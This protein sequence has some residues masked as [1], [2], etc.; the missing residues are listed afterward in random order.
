MAVDRREQTGERCRSKATLAPCGPVPVAGRLG[1][2][3]PGCGL[4]L[5]GAWTERGLYVSSR[6]AVAERSLTRR[7]SAELRRSLGSTPRGSAKPGGA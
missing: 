4:D 2:G 1:K 7:S 3:R 6:S 5:I